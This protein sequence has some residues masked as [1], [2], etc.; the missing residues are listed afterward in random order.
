[1]ASKPKI[2]SLSPALRR[3][4]QSVTV[5]NLW[6][7]VLSLACRRKIYAYNL[8][9]E[10]QRAFGFTPSRLLVYLVLYRLEGEELLTSAE[11]G[12]RRYY[13]ITAKGRQALAQGKG[14]LK[15]RGS[16]L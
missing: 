9:E 12:R 10:I 14:L 3:L 1:M 11:D 15:K 7:S 2:S 8:P 5:G 6:L 4:E 16:E 13:S